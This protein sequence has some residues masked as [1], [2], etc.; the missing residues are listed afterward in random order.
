MRY[1]LNTHR[2]QGEVWPSFKLGSWR[3]IV[4]LNGLISLFGA[5]TDKPP[6]RKFCARNKSHATS[7]VHIYDRRRKPRC[8]RRTTYNDTGG[9]FADWQT[10]AADTNCIFQTTALH[11]SAWLLNQRFRLRRQ[12]FRSAVCHWRGNTD[13]LHKN[14]RLVNS[15][16]MSCHWQLVERL[17]TKY[18]AS[19]FTFDWHDWEY[20]RLVSKL[21]FA[22]VCWLVCL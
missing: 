10:T 14:I 2:H 13:W 20:L 16:S 7:Y 19:T 11:W 15:F 8:Y 4:W 17:K 22:S 21:C 18:A 1:L 5:Q 9:S 12:R 6:K 3:I